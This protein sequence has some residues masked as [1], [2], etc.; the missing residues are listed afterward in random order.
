M[1]SRAKTWLDVGAHYGYTAFA[2]AKLVGPTGRVFTFEPVAATAGCIDQAR[3]LNRFEQLTV[4]P[5]GLGAAE[6]LETRRLPLTARHG[7]LDALSTQ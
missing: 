4:L 6:T 2:R 1:S 7:R 5:F 3:T